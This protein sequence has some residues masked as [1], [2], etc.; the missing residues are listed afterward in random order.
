MEVAET[1]DYETVSIIGNRESDI[2]IGDFIKN[3]SRRAALT[4]KISVFNGFKLP[5]CSA[6]TD[7]PFENHIHTKRTAS[8]CL[9]IYNYTIN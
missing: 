6:V 8:V 4:Y 5:R 1:G 7:I 9:L 3:P 2:F